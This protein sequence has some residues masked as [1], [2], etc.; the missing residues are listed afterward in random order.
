LSSTRAGS[1]PASRARCF[2]PYTRAAGCPV[3]RILS[4]GGVTKPSF[5]ERPFYPP[6]AG[7]SPDAPYLGYARSRPVVPVAP[8]RDAGHSRLQP[9]GTRCERASGHRSPPARKFA[10]DAPLMGGD[11]AIGI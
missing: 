5:W 2:R 6:L 4:P 7:R 1:S 11:V 3:S 9:P 10:A 8:G